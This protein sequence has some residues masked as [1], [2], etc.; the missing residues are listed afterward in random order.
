MTGYS[1]REIAKHFK[2]DPST[3]HRWINSG[4]PTLE[5]GEVGRGHTSRLDPQAVEQ[6]LV[7]QLVPTLAHRVEQDVP[8]VEREAVDVVDR[9]ALKL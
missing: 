2:R 1:V 7:S 5:L 9:L 4:C 6:W 3:V 8:L